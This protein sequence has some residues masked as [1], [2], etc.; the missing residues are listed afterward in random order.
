M[1]RFPL[2][3][4]ILLWFF[5]N[6]VLLASAFYVLFRAQFRIGL[7]WVL[8]SGAGERIE[9]LSDI[10]FA[11]MEAGPPA[12]WPEVLQ[13]FGRPYQL[14]LYVFR[15]DGSQLAGESIRLPLEVQSRLVQRDRPML[16]RQGFGQAGLEP[17]PP[18]PSEGPDSEPQPPDG[19]G[20]RR[21]RMGRGFRGGRPFDEPAPERRPGFLPPLAGQ[22]RGPQPKSM[23]RT[24]DPTRYWLLVRGMLN[25]GS[26]PLPMPVTLV[27]RSDSLSGG[28]L[29][30]DFKPWLFTALGAVIFSVL[31]WLP[32]VRGITRSVAQMTHATRQIAEG[33][34]EVRV[35]ER[36]RDELGALGQS[37]N[38][39]AARLAGLMTG[40]KRFLGDIAHELCSPL[41]KLRVALGI[42]E[43]RA[44]PQQQNYVTAANEKAEHMANLVNELLSFTRASLGSASLQLQPVSVR[45]AAEQAVHREAHDGQKIQLDIPDGVCV[46]AETELLVRALANLLRNSIRYAGHAGPITV[47]AQARNG[48]VELTVAD[49]GPGVPEEELARL[50]DPFYRV[51]VSR[52]RATGGVG[53]GLSIVKTCIESC[54][55][56]VTC[57]NRK[58]SGLEV[59]IRLPA[60]S[61]KTGDVG[62]QH[63]S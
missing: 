40:Q 2:L 21:P 26:R 46:L 48:E 34:F 42:L 38:R 18:A 57:R 17:L 28:G 50:F 53:L 4:K 6:L 30:F 12:T 63:L 29:F 54:R 44:D 10:I 41:A 59:M 49:N 19:P 24:T 32:L 62:S 15:G 16:R 45:E 5:L 35:D 13:R 51:D 61:G 47:A 52:D 1:T 37:I 58:P 22:P 36:R 9:A 14:Q 43:Q 56:T 33:R 31:F 23:V 39:M 3:A 11:E 20:P 25:D 7:D 60:A 8:N 27:A 55:G